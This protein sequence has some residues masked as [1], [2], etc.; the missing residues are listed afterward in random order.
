MRDADFLTQ[1]RSTEGG[2][3]SVCVSTVPTMES[4]KHLSLRIIGLSDYL[5]TS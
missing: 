1:P 5:F 3:S 2:I 4:E